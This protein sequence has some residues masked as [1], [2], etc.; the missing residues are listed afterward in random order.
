MRCRKTCA[1]ATDTWNTIKSTENQSNTKKKREEKINAPCYPYMVEKKKPII[2]FEIK[3]TQNHTEAKALSLCALFKQTIYVV[4]LCSS[5]RYFTYIYEYINICYTWCSECDVMLWLRFSCICA[6]RFAYRNKR[7][8][9]RHKQSSTADQ[10]QVQWYT[11]MRHTT[12]ITHRSH[13]IPVAAYMAVLV[14][15]CVCDVCNVVSE[16]HI[17]HTYAAQCQCGHQFER[18]TRLLHSMKHTQSR[19]PHWSI[20]LNL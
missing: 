5:Y 18:F 6:P 19:A 4:G 3:Q 2:R 12:P 9:V 14:R 11:E 10:D 7:T 17:H 13:P 8:C 15:Y 16:N 20:N 1:D